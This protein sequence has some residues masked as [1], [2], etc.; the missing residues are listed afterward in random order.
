[1]DERNKPKS[2]L[3][4]AEIQEEANEYGVKVIDGSARFKAIG[5]VGGVAP[6]QGE[7][8]NSAELSQG[9]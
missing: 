2:V 8:A 3:S 7:T 9:G 4:L 5:I 6:R 1:M